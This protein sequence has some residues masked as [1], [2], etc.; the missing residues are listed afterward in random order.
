MAEPNL[1]LADL[2]DAVSKGTAEGCLRALWHATDVLVSGTY[3][4]A[5]IWTFGEIIARL[6]EE[7]ELG[8]RIQLAKKLAPSKNA[9]LKIIKRLAS[10]DWIE[11]AGPVLG[12]SERLDVDTLIAV[13]RDKDQ[14][15][16]LAISRRKSIPEEVTDILVVRGGRMV[17]T[18]VAANHGA[19]FS[20]SGFRHLVRRSEGN[21][22]LA[23]SVGLREDIPT[24]LFQQL[25]SRASE[26]VRTKL[27]QERPDMEEQIR[28]VVTDVAGPIHAGLGPA[29]KDYSA[30]ERT[31]TKLHQRGKLTEDEVFAFAH[32]LKFNETAVALSLL[33]SLPTGIVERALVDKNRES[34]L[35]LAKGLDFS[36]TTA[37]SLLFLG[38][39]NYR[40]TAGDLDR[41]K[42]DF[43][44]LKKE[45]CLRV[46]DVY[47]T[48]RGTAAGDSDGLPPRYL[49]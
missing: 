32:S 14:Q 33:C 19:H 1:S 31:V 30:A 46:L 6:A 7:I 8:A 10:D 44:R 23:E 28:S 42:I 49:N 22:V 4:E 29:S 40:I 34:I 41:M 25:I 24:H 37:M 26:Q 21:S 12:Q 18:A 11:V 9:P 16:L 13:A 43:I 47:R 38:A 3:S 2:E 35:I 15:H 48:R 5:Q 39:P 36:W 17:V 45:T 27:L 20:D